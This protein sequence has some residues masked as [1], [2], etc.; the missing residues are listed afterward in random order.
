[1]PFYI[2][3]YLKEN[4]LKRLYEIDPTLAI[5]EE[6]LFVCRQMVNSHQPPVDQV[7]Q[8]SETGWQVKYVNLNQIS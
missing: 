1:M 2:K 6:D 7:V 8:V 3:A 4:A 5:K